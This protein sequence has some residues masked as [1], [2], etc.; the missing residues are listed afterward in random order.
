SL[1]FRLEKLEHVD[2]R[3]VPDDAR[4]MLMARW[5][6]IIDLLQH[7]YAALLQTNPKWWRLAELILDA[8]EPFGV[9]LANRLAAQ[10][11]RDELLIEFEWSEHASPVRVHSLSEARRANEFFDRV[12]VSGNWKDWQRPLVFGMLPR[13]VQV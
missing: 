1:K 8:T 11:L 12:V 5:P 7:A 9:L 13:E 4:G 2:W 10:G 6:Q 3:L